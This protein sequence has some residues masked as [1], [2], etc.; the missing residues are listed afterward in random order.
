VPA[1]PGLVEVCQQV[2]R[3][4]QPLQRERDVGVDLGARVGAPPEPLDVKAKNP[5]KTPDPELLGG[6]LFA[7]AR[8]ANPVFRLGLGQRYKTSLNLLQAPQNGVCS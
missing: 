5:G 1:A 8:P 6:A 4:V 2:V 7:L 3:H